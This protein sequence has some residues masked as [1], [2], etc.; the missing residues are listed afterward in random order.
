M[1]ET[2]VAPRPWHYRLLWIIVLFSLLL[3]LLLLIGLFTARSIAGAEV[4]KVAASLRDNPMS[5]LEIPITIDESLPIAMN[6]P[7]KDTFT[8]TISETIPVS[9]SVLFE[10]NI[11]IPIRETVRID[12]NVEVFVVI[13]VINQRVPIQIPI[14]ANIPIALDI[15]VPVSYEIPVQTDIPINFIVEV[16]VETEVP[17]NTEVPVKMEFP[18]TVPMENLEVNTFLQQ[19]QEGLTRLATLLGADN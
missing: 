4:A 11:A 14:G 8:V 17:I 15:N 3:N 2:T 5:D 1:S 13:P 10:E 7:F 16:P 12:H 18:V 19:L 6:V 9:T